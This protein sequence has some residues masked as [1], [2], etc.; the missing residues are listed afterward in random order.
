MKK[1]RVTMEGSQ[2]FN[3]EANNKQE[4]ID[5]VK[6]DLSEYDPLDMMLEYSAEE[7]S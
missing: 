6:E 3:V 1:F 2:I 7:V 5:E 4:A